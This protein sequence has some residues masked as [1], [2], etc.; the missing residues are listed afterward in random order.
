MNQEEFEIIFPDFYADFGCR[1]NFT[2]TP[3][4]KDLLISGDFD[5]LI[6]KVWEEHIP[7][8]YYIVLTWKTL[9]VGRCDCTQAEYDSQLIPSKIIQMVNS[10]ILATS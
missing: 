3:S 9:E 8:N 5:G 7:S 4:D 1:I 10:F 2:A 6:E